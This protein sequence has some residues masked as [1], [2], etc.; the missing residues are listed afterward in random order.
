VA[1]LRIEV[2]EIRPV[3]APAGERNFLIRS[4][5]RIVGIGRMK[6]MM[7]ERAQMRT[8]S[9]GNQYIER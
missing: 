6:L 1:V 7:V 8:L 9:A 2:V 3:Q 4:G 5:L